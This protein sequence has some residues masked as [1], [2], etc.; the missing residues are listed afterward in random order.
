MAH[1]RQADHG[2]P[3]AA[4]IFAAAVVAVTTSL[5]V[6]VASGALPNIGGVADPI[7]RP[8]VGPTDPVWRA[9]EDWEHQRRQQSTFIDPVLRSADDWEEQRLQQSPYIDW[10]FRSAAS[11]EEQRLQQSGAE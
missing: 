11:W 4:I 1:T 3:Q 2:V 6:L 10:A 9:A 8:G 7:A 5:G